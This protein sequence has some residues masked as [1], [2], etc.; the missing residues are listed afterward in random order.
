[1][2]VFLFLMWYNHLCYFWNYFNGGIKT[3]G[4]VDYVL[5]ALLIIF[6]LIVIVVILLQEGRRKGMSGVIAGG[7][8]TFLAK[9]KARAVDAV[10]SRWTK[11]IAIGFFLLVL[12]ANIVAYFMQ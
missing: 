12:A 11:F 3:M 8:D 6:A 9:G 4:V 5:G 7:A 1:M 2:L 10:L